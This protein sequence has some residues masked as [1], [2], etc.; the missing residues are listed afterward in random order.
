[1]WHIFTSCEAH[2][3]MLITPLQ[4]SAIHFCHPSMSGPPQY[5]ANVSI[6]VDPCEGINLTLS[7]PPPPNTNITYSLY[8]SYT[9]KLLIYSSFPP[10]STTTNIPAN[11]LTNHSGLYWGVVTATNLAGNGPPTIITIDLSQGN[12]C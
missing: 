9:S 2:A 1:M 11:L 8:D 10:N 3:S 4:V 12:N 7:A 6:E 5:I